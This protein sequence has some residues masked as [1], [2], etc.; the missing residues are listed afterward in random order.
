MRAK[1]GGRAGGPQGTRGARELTTKVRTA[2]RRSNA[3]TRWLNRQLN[4]PYVA[5]AKRDG[6]K[7]R[8]AYKL[9]ELDERFG[10]LKRGRRVLDLGAAP[11]GWCQVAAAKL[12]DSGRVV[13]VDLL[14]FG[15]IPGAACYRL[16]VETP[17][18]EAKM[19]AWLGGR[20]DLVLSD[21]A[22]NTT[23]HAATDRIRI[24]ALAEVAYDVAARM[25][26]PDGGFVVKLFQG[27]AHNELLTALKRDFAAVRHA[28]PPASR[29]D[30]SEL[31]LVA[32]GFRGIPRNDAKTG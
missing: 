5:A 16:D 30:S 20:A 3:S 32:R 25:L 23:G 24:A 29:K 9:A 1:G 31:Y 6:Y 27:G 15:P 11:G 22:P 21:M 18:S 13:G 4:D 14:P 2:R 17:S 12:G 28:K 26:A 8:A 7:S 19:L 10:L